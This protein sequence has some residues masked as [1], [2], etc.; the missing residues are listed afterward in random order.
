MGKE[1]EIRS[2][3]TI[4]HGN[5]AIGEVRIADEV[6]AGIAGIAATEIEGVASMS[7]NITKDLIGKLGNGN[8][9][10]GVTL[11]IEENKVRVDIALYMDYGYSVPKVCRKVQE[12]VKTAV[13]NM[14]GMDVTEVNVRI[15]G[16][17]IDKSKA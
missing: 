14:T 15:A 6:I 16:V 13:E 9:S 12:R 17:N 8:L 11:Q 4:R 2:T 5:E 1:A 10:K 3:H 7:G